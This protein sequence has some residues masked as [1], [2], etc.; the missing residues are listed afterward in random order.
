MQR[1]KGLPYLFIIRI[2][3]YSSSSTKASIQAHIKTSRY[4][5]NQTVGLIGVF[6]SKVMRTSSKRCP[7]MN[8]RRFLNCPKWGCK[9]SFGFPLSPSKRSP[10]QKTKS[11]VNR[12]P[13]KFNHS[14]RVA[15][16][17]YE[18]GPGDMSSSHVQLPPDVTPQWSRFP[19][20]TCS[21]RTVLKESVAL[22][23]LHRISP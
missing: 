20:K 3:P 11:F 17:C 12:V 2:L 10:R 5:T 14:C 13:T 18:C 16:S 9:C 8:R 7:Y 21:Q 15:A 19:G 23:S 6:R 22:E 4:C 1:I